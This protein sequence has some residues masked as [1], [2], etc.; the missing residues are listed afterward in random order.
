[1]PNTILRH[2]EAILQTGSVVAASRK[3]FVSQPS[4]SQYVRR[5]EAE[6][7]ITIFDRA[8]SPWRLTEEGERLLEAQ[9]RM[10][11]IDRECRQFFADRRGLKTGSIRIGSTAYRTATLLNPVLSV[12]KQ[13]YPKISVQVEEGT[14]QEVIDWAESG[15]VDCSFAVT[16]MVPETMQKVPVFSEK[17]LLGLS[18]GHALA[19]GI[20]QAASPPV[21][22]FRRL[23]QTPFIIM[24]KGQIFHEYYSDLCRRYGVRPPVAL[25]TQSILTVPALIA[26][27]LGGALIPSTIA[28]D[29]RAHGVAL[30]KLPDGDLPEN[31]VSVAW[32]RN[33]YMSF[34]AK[35]FVKACQEILGKDQPLRQSICGRAGRSGQKKRF[36]PLPGSAVR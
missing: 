34:A 9:R 33:R 32:K 30:F 21:I 14:T 28:S 27:G 35:A 31:E 23:A 36:S 3:L 20:E 26:T 25:E 11:A 1:M 29:C 2:I 5:L 16:A 10:D 12:F 22:D 15:R 18:A 24:K 8:E 4:L 19:A 7:G 6:Y 17:V 13:R